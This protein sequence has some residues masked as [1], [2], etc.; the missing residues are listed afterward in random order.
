MRSDP[1][2]AATASL[3]RVA[4]VV[5]AYY[6]RSHADVIVS[7]L[8]AGHTYP[9]PADL[10]RYDFHRGAQ[11][12]T[13]R[14]LPRDAAGRLR[15]PRVQVASLYT[16]QVPANDIG[17]QWAAR[18]GVPIYPT[19]R[20]ALTL[21][22]DRLAVDGV[23][24]VGEHGDYP[25]NERGQQ[26][27]PRRR[28][29]EEAVAVIRE[30]GRPVPIFVDKHLAYAWDDAKWMYDTA[31]ALRLPLMAGSSATTVPVGWR[32]P[33][34]ELPLGTPIHRALVLAEGG[35]ESYGFHALEVLQCMVERRAGAETG[36]G[37]VQ[38]LGGAAVWEAGDA[39]LWDRSL[40]AAALALADPPLAGDVR[41][42]VREPVVFLLHYRDGLRAAVCMFAGV[43]PGRVF[44][45]EVTLPGASGRTVVAT[46]F[47]GHSQ[48][49]YGH[50]AYLV[51][52]IQ[53]LVCGGEE[54]WPVERT[55]LT[56]GVLDRLMESRWRGGVR[57]ETPEL[58]IKYQA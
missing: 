27:Y 35:I 13:E 41:A 3:I 58:A 18:G 49:P 37:A 48:E 1:A 36:V 22:G 10:S 8:L 40:L 24:I 53:D 6:P 32:Q 4:A 14:P 15:R 30:S 44:A 54:P 26:R 11:E 47:H 7:R 55:L 52:R 21:G 56:T 12:L 51:E 5:T 42:L 20:E 28:L 57:L 45:G 33:P 23:I 31:R 46:G 34:F 17:R 43:G 39:G 19:V 38:C 25:V 9:G 16:D 2:R 29:F 50:F